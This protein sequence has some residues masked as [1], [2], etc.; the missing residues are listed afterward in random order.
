MQVYLTNLDNFPVVKGLE[1]VFHI[2]KKS[3]N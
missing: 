1:E 3:R 2:E